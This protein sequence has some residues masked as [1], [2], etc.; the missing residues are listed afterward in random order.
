MKMDIDIFQIPGILRRRWYYLAFFAALFAGLALLYALSLKPVYVSSTQIL[1]DPRGLS[2][3]SN[4]SRQPTAA[5]Q[6][7]P[8]SLDSQI[9]VVLSSAV[10]GEVVNRLDLTKDPY[11][12]AG[13]PDSAA[14]LAEVMAATIGGLVRHVKVEREGQS[15]IMSITVE[16][17]IAK[18]AADIANMIAT[19]YLKQVDEARSDA[20]R[21]A[22]AAFQ[23]QASELRDRVLKAERA[24]EEFRSANGLAS[25]GVTGLVIDQQLAGLN[26]QLIAARGAEEQQQAIYQ[27]T[28]NL[29]VAAVE[30]GNIPEAVQST[31]VGLLRDRYVQLQD[32]QAE[33]SANLGGNHPQLKAINSQVASMRQAIQQE[34]DRVRQS[35]KLNYDRAVANRKALETQ[36][37]SLTKTSFDSGARQITLRQLESEAEAIRTIYKA[38]L[39]RAEELSQEQT[40]SIN[41]SRVITEAV[42][43]AKSVTTLKV[44]ILAAAIL[45]GLAFGS[46]LAVVL[47]L[48]SRK[49]IDAPRQDRIV[50]VAATP[51]NSEPQLAPP[52]ASSRHI[53]LIA[54]ATEPKRP[55]S[56][57]PF[58]FITAFGRRLVSPLVPASNPANTQQPAAGGAW[59]HAVANTAGFLIECGEGYADLTVL[60]VAAGRPVAS[61]FIGDVAQKLVDR[62][63]GVLLANGTMLDHRLAIRS[64]RKTNARPSLAQALQQ[65]D[66][67]D[68]PLSHILRYERI[69]LP[70]NQPA[71]PAAGASAASVRPTYSRFVEQS[72][73]A[74]TDFTLINACGAGFNAS[75]AGSEQHL[76]ALA[77]EAD[78]I[79]VLTTAQDE[80]A[81]LDE[82]LIRMGED[83]ERVVGRIVL[84][85]AG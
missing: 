25:T 53:A 21:R 18:T 51:T 54:D 5:V 20:A 38:F 32:R 6:S 85:T 34:L 71:R 23:A 50:P 52:V 7:D 63:R 10:L 82:L 60:F 84:E 57:N 49:D 19:V 83:A 17:R 30:N 48:L 46:T 74:E 45:F 77:A 31:T 56:R 79:L 43:T 12:Y 28:R 35:M 22:S 80:T 26:Q 66:L 41:N 36:L 67:E 14:S 69:A 70:H 13:K 81:A 2:A 33:A 29:T 61:A 62:D 58:S 75:G 8:A 9:Y 68:A 39:N 76:T 24:V 78:V 40:I 3:T 4:D 11:L 1:L 59:S 64:H 27:Q 55:R 65:P 73:Q 15:F 37:Q 47:E 72:L 42:A 44:M 16:H